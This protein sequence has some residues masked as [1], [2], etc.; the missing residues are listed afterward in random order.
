METNNMGRVTTAARIENLQDLWD[1]ERGLLTSDIVRAISI[2]DALVDTGATMLSLPS[3]LISQLGLKKMYSKNVIGSTGVTQANVYA[4][5][6]LT[7]GDRY[8]NLDIMEVP[9][10]VPALIGQ[11]PLE[12]LDFVVDPRSRTLIGNPAHGGEHV[13]EAF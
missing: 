9:D 7:I 5:A 13:L 3:G 4:A 11:I 12:Q 8:C 6:R 2:A 1:V 10:N